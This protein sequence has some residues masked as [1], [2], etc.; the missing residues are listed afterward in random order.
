MRHRRGFNAATTLICSKNS[1]QLHHQLFSFSPVPSTL[2]SSDRAAINQSILVRCPPVHAEQ[3]Q[4][5]RTNAVA[6]FLA[7]A[8][9]AWSRCAEGGLLCSE[10]QAHP[11]T[12][13]GLRC[14]RQVPPRK[15]NA[16]SAA[17]APKATG[18]STTHQ[19]PRTRTRTR[20]THHTPHTTAQH[21]YRS[22]LLAGRAALRGLLTAVPSGVRTLA[23]SSSSVE[24]A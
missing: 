16:A 4:S 13:P 8:L 14:S 19:A 12:G 10:L 15:H 11:H 24:A 22:L 23:P 17:A 3:I 20:T 6:A 1:V 18:Y 7:P 2:R 9:A 5:I 21:A